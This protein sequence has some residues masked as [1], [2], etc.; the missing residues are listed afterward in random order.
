M[1]KSRFKFFAYTA[2]GLEK[3]L[4]NDLRTL[5]IKCKPTSLFG[6]KCIEFRSNLEDLVRLLLKTRT[7]GDLKMMVGRP[8][9]CGTIKS[10]EPILDGNSSLQAFLELNDFGI[11]GNQIFFFA[12]F[13]FWVGSVFFNFGKTFNIFESFKFTKNN[14]LGLI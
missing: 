13:I 6:T 12:Y 2:F 10:L 11:Q 9:H 3:A 7:L 14:F 1:N 8:A 4:L 5:K